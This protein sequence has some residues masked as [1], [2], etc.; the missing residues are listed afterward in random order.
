MGKEEEDKMNRLNSEKIEKLIINYFE[1]IGQLRSRKRTIK[2]KIDQEQSTLKR[3]Q[4]DEK[5]FLDML[6]SDCTGKGEYHD[7]I[8]LP[9][10]I[11]M[12]LDKSNHLSKE[13]ADALKEKYELTLAYAKRLEQRFIELRDSEGQRM[14]QIK[15]SKKN[16]K[17][18]E[19]EFKKI[20][21]EYKKNMSTIKKLDY[22]LTSI[23]Q[24]DS[25]VLQY[26]SK[27]NK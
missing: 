20:E 8:M 15:K 13:E 10:D 19:I 2:H 5:E 1:Y 22:E 26:N 12:Q 24:D 21:K 11:K 4:K 3:L 14:N 7:C 9:V 27:N 18:Y 6:V 25:K 16:I 23:K 17:K